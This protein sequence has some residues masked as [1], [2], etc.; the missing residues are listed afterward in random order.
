MSILDLD[1]PKNRFFA[2]QTFMGKETFHQESPLNAYSTIFRS[3]PTL[4]DH[5]ETMKAYKVASHLRNAPP[6]KKDLKSTLSRFLANCKNLLPLV[7]IYSYFWE[8]ILH[9]W[10]LI[11]RTR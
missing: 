10:H 11:Y 2:H 1:I 4:T 7:V 5:L 8:F 3:L 9:T 6:L